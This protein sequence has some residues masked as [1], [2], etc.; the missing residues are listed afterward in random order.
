MSSRSRMLKRG[1]YW[2]MKFCS[3][4]SASASVWTTRLSQLV[5][6]VGQRPAAVERRVAEVR[7]DA[8]ADRLR[9]ADVDHAPAAVAE[10]VD[11][12]L[13]GQ[14]ATL[15]GEPLAPV[16]GGVCARGHISSVRG[17]GARKTVPTLRNLRG[18]KATR[19]ELRGS[20][21]PCA[22]D[23]PFPSPCCSPS[24]WPHPRTPPTRS[25]S[26][27][28]PPASS[29]ILTGRT[30]R[31]KKIR[32]IV[33]WDVLKYPDQAG[34]A[35]D[36]LTK[37]RAANQEV[38]L[39]FTA[40]QGCYNNGRY[41]RSSVCRAPSVSAYKAQF[42]AFK[43]EVPVDPPL[44]GLERGQPRL[45]ADR[46][47]PAP[48]GPLLQLRALLL[49]RQLQ[50]DGRRPA[51]REHAGHVPE[52]V[53][54]LRQRQPAPVG[55]AQLQGRQPA[56]GQGPADDARRGPRRGLA[57]R[58]RRHRQ[59]RA[60]LPVL[61][62]PRGLAHALPVPAGRQVRPRA[63]RPARQARPR[64]QLP[65]VRRARGLPLRRGPRGPGRHAARGAVDLRRATRAPTARPCPP[66]GA[67]G[68]RT[69][70][71]RL[72]PGW[73]AS[74][75]GPARC[76]RR[77]AASR[78]R[79]TT[80]AVVA[81]RGD[82]DDVFSHGFLCPKGASLKE[83]HEDPDRLRTPL[84][85]DAGGQLVAVLVGEAFA[86]IAERLPALH[87]GVARRGGRLHRQP[88]RPLA[89]HDASTDARWSRR[90]ARATCSPP[91]RSTRCPSTCPPG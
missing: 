49:P 27:S 88:D 1:L 75:T 59:A 42:R 73:S 10:Q 57:D 18:I 80:D 64:L 25:A 82:A 39:S 87:A 28:S 29:P 71:G 24:R 38:L 76:A 66:R 46:P 6:L 55:P 72:P 3:V 56:P 54:A 41:S 45:P 35:A 52:P 23:T 48:G 33:P 62:L 91:R 60:E 36:Y 90:S 44:R 19:A 40:H 67:P 20:W 5:D 83:L 53:P 58:D 63:L 30:C 11:A 68:R 43:A 84:V 37:A 12:G 86:A 69:A 78:S 34:V 70:G 7:G 79:S 21:P 51:R 16:G 13:V 47:Q 2:R 26:A 65:L 17:Y 81:I 74:P 77:P 14:R 31:L 15:L 50:A 61:A 4:S 9:L 85:R 8:L 32:Y 89:G 22:F